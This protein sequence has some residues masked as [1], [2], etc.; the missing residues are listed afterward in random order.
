MHVGR[1]VV[2]ERA[3]AAAADQT[4]QAQLG[5]VLADR[6]GGGADQFGQAGHRR[7]AVQQRP[8]NLY[9]GG[10]GEQPEGFGGEVDLLV[11]G[12]LEI[13]QRPVHPFTLVRASLHVCTSACLCR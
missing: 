5:Q 12:H 2:H 11:V 3:L 4:G 10:V 1:G 7:L 6:R 9:A 13:R 8:E